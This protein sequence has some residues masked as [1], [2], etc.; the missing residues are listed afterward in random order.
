MKKYKRGLLERVLSLDLLLISLPSLLFLISILLKH[1]GG[2]QMDSVIIAAMISAGGA[3]VIGV[4]SYFLKTLKDSKVIISIQEDT[5]GYKPNIDL[6]PK[7]DD[8][9]S[10]LIEDGKELSNNLSKNNSVVE[11]IQ[12]NVSFLR[13]EAMIEKELR[14]RVG[15]P[16]QSGMN[17]LKTLAEQNESLKQINEKYYKDNFEL[18]LL[19]E[20]KENTIR[21]LRERIETLELS[22]D[23]FENEYDEP[24]IKQSHHKG[25]GL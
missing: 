20:E 6:I 23:E 8:K 21:I 22:I 1:L 14:S 25:L 12:T 2:N 10:K 18:S 13:D 5:I 16:Y 4:F 3:I 15:E 11:S 19:I 24:E 7:I 17:A 9:S